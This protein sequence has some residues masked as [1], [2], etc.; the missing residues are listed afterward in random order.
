MPQQIPKG[1]SDYQQGKPSPQELGRRGGSSSYETQ[2]FVANE[3]HELDR[4]GSPRGPVN[5]QRFSQTK[6]PLP[7]D[8]KPPEKSLYDID[9]LAGQKCFHT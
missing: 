2:S 1:A 8:P 7:P 9:A 4:F 6:R 5:D 3:A